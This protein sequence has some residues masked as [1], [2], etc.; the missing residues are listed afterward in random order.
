MLD[1]LL[2]QKNSCPFKIILF[3]PYRSIRTGELYPD[4]GFL[5]EK[6][7]EETLD[8]HRCEDMGPA[9]KFTGLL[10]Y[11]PLIKDDV[12]HVYITDDDIILHPNVFQRVLKK[13]TKQPSRPTL[14]RTVLAND[15]G[16]LN[17]LPTVA[18]YA[19][20]L[21][22]FTFFLEMASDTN[23]TPVWTALAEG[24]HPCFDVDDILL[25]M[26]IRRFG[27]GVETTGLD[28]FK[29]VMNRSLTDQHPEWFELCKHTTRPQKTAQCKDV[30]LP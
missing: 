17:D 29:E 24:E 13:I 16:M 1:A 22:P 26:L 5:Q 4:P 11:M 18:G 15:T 14:D 3:L 21:F 7:G 19:G 23:L 30:I 27:Y 12:T 20:I 2:A 8:I 6:Y 9:T 25:S 10:S 28:P